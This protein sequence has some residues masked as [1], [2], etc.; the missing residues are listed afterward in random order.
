MS[1]ETLKFK[2]AASSPVIRHPQTA[3]KGTG[4]HLGSMRATSSGETSDSKTETA[5]I[6]DTKTKNKT[7]NKFEVA[8][9]LVGLKDTQS[10]SGNICKLQSAER[11]LR[12]SQVNLN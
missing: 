9:T 4:F 7:D 10:K 3:R 11:K 5:E 8:Q 2:P 12:I 6:C 1:L